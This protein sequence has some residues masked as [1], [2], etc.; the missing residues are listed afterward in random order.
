MISYLTYLVVKRAFEIVIKYLNSKECKAIN[1]VKEGTPDPDEDYKEDVEYI[2]NVIGT[3]RQYNKLVE[4]AREKF[5]D[6]KH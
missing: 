4:Y 6:I 5:R 1:N 2:S 3:E